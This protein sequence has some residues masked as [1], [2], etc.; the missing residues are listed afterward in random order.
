MVE[1]YPFLS[2]LNTEHGRR[3]RED[4][5]FATEIIKTLDRCPPH[6]RGINLR[7]LINTPYHGPYGEDELLRRAGNQILEWVNKKQTGFGTDEDI[8]LMA[9]IMKVHDNLEWYDPANEG[10]VCV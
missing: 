7:A 5:D 4:N 6:I 3:S 2:A 9:N 10:I 8:R 1:T